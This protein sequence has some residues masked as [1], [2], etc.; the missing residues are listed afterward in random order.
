MKPHAPADPVPVVS[1]LVM[2]SSG[3]RPRHRLH[4]GPGW[5]ANNY[6]LTIQLTNTLAPH[7]V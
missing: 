3:F 1:L 4:D 6:R 7:S 5:I 2:Q